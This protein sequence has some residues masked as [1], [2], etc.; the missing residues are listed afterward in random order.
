MAHCLAE[1]TAL[2]AMHYPGQQ[3]YWEA[4][5]TFLCFGWL[6]NSLDVTLRTASF[7][8]ETGDG[9]FSLGDLWSRWPSLASAFS[10]ET[11]GPLPVT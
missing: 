7:E 5:T 8:A 2:D 9:R 4:G 10:A 11:T 6:P 3:I 1:Y